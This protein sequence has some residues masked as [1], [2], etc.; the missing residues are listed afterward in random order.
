VTLGDIA[1]FFK[2]NP[3]VQAR[4]DDTITLKATMSDLFDLFGEQNVKTMV[5]EKTAEAARK[6]DYER[7][8]SNIIDNWVTLGI[9]II[10]FAVL[11]V[12]SLELIDRDKR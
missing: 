4:R 1:D 11:S 12:I 9:F 7:T 5:Q 10:V 3:A 8:E 6:P 2:N